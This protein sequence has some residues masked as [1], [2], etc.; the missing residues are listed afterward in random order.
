MSD[1]KHGRRE[2][3]AA[4][5]RKA[6]LD[7]AKTLF[8]GKGF[9]NTS[10]GD[11]AT[12]ANVSKGAVYHHFDDKQEIFAQLFRESLGGVLQAVA[13]SM[14]G[15]DQ[16]WARVDAA[17]RTFLAVYV[18]DPEA[19]MLLQQVVGVLGEQRTR[20]LDEEFALPIIRA[21]LVE[22]DKVGELKPVSIDATARIIF[23]VLC[24]AAS[25]LVDATNAEVA[26]HELEVAIL[27]MFSGFRRSE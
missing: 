2:I 16:P 15:F 17:T 26:A 5:T 14:L 27:C 22:L 6:V 9:A 1:V 18:A 4:L 25:S 3:Y 24:G 10:V 8:V 11:I 19:R 13:D 21:M 23:D 20:A 7:A 12:L